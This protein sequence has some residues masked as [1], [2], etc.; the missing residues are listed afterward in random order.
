MLE[1]KLDQKLEEKLGENFEQRF[2]NMP[3]KD[4]F[5]E[6]MDEVMGEPRA[7]RDE[8]TILGHRGSEHADRIEVLEGLH[9]GGKHQLSA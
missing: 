7:L 3:T 1:Q 2:R 5:Y 4:E 9:P 6:K 8:V